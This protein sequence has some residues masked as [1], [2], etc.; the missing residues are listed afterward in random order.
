MVDDGINGYIYTE[1]SQLSDK[2]IKMFEL[3]QSDY[4]SM[5]KQSYERAKMLFDA[6]SY[7]DNLL[8]EYSKIKK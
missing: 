6:N 7:I 5:C 3:S 4:S 1:K 2:L 8:A